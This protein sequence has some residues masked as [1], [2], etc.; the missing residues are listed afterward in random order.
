M[1]YTITQA[2]SEPRYRLHLTY[3]DGVV[4][5]VNLQP[6]IERGGVFA[7]LADPEFF[8]QVTLGERG[9]YIEWNGAIDFCADALRRED[10]FVQESESI[11]S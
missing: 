5:V 9:C 11:A 7:A 3:S 2:I 6:V 10:C 1:L 8:A 4:I